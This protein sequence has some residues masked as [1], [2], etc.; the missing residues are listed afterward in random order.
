MEFFGFTSSSSNMEPNYAFPET[1]LKGY[2]TD[3]INMVPV[4]D[5]TVVDT[6]GGIIQ[7]TALSQ[8]FSVSNIRSLG[9]EF[10]L[11]V[12]KML[13]ELVSL[14]EKPFL[15]HVVVGLVT[16]AIVYGTLKV[17]ASW[18][19]E[20]GLDTSLNCATTGINPDLTTRATSHH[21]AQ[22]MPPPKARKTAN[23]MQ[24]VL[25]RKPQ[26]ERTEVIGDMKLP[27]YLPTDTELRARSAEAAI[28]ND[29]NGVSM[30]AIISSTE[31]FQRQLGEALGK[32]DEVRLKLIELENDKNLLLAEI[33]L[34]KKIIYRLQ[35]ENTSE[36][37]KRQQAE[38]KMEMMEIENNQLRQ[39][40]KE[41]LLKTSQVERLEKFLREKEEQQERLFDENVVL[42]RSVATV[43]AKEF[44]ELQNR[45]ERLESELTLAAINTNSRSQIPPGDGP[46]VETLR[47]KNVCSHATST[48]TV[49]KAEPEITSSISRNTFSKANKYTL[50]FDNRHTQIERN[51]EELEKTHPKVQSAEAPTELCPISEVSHSNRSQ[52]SKGVIAQLRAFITGANGSG[53]ESEVETTRVEEELY[54]PSDGQSSV[55]MSASCGSDSSET[56]VTVV[57]NKATY[58]KSQQRTNPNKRFTKH[59]RK[60]ASEKDVNVSKCQ[61]GSQDT[62]NDQNGSLSNAVASCCSETNSQSTSCSRS[63]SLLSNGSSKKENKDNPEA[64]NTCSSEEPGTESEDS[65]IVIMPTVG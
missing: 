18:N 4:L 9:A 24:V 33:D 37:D 10:S 23:N 21:R 19:E 3:I 62:L 64:A 26:K 55:F 54:Q 13:D 29:A 45:V 39:L 52:N 59:K 35:N 12:K 28:G 51:N 15:R 48:S 25:K 61:H 6:D 30:E 41:L 65:W 46:S 2:N 60:T 34:R 49:C 14:S 42:P 43:R 50:S 47:N 40:R 27:E 8:L 5:T 32:L 1:I 38:L 36:R 58:R 20:I 53:S 11:M 7:L 17:N 16:A 31:Q 44:G 56:E 22:A 57:S 63:N